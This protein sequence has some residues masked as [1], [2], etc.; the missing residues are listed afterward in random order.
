[1]EFFSLASGI[2]RLTVEVVVSLE[3]FAETLSVITGSAV[4]ALE[5]IPAAARRICLAFSRHI[6]VLSKAVAPPLLGVAETAGESFSS[7]A[8]LGGGGAMLKAFGQ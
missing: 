6:R 8:A 1:M 2:D 4:D 3:L 7:L 5:V